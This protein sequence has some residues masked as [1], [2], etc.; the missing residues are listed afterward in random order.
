M[1]IDSTER[2]KEE[3]ARAEFSAVM[4]KNLSA[5]LEDVVGTA[6]TEASANA[7]LAANPLRCNKVI[8]DIFLNAGSGL[9]V[10]QIA[11]LSDGS[12][13]V[14]AIADIRRRC[15]ELGACR[16]FDKSCQFDELVDN[17]ARLY[18]GGTGLGEL[19]PPHRR[20]A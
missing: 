8:V 11:P 19:A 2:K 10:R 14:D 16:V 4:R 6:D 17:C 3:A 15:L 18:K 12:G 5:A 1:T 9:G 20:V 7:W 13:R